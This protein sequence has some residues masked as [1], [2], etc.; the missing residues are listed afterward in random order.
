MSDFYQ[1]LRECISGYN[2][3]FAELARRTQIDRS[4]LYKIQNGQ[5]LPT[6]E[7]LLR[8]LAELK[9]SPA[10]NRRIMDQYGSLRMDAGQLALYHQLHAVLQPLLGISTFTPPR[11][12]FSVQPCGSD[13]EVLDTPAALQA[14]LAELM[15]A[16]LASETDK[17][18]MLSPYLPDSLL[19]PLACGLAADGGAAR[20]HAVWHLCCA[21][22]QGAEPQ[23][24]YL[25][26]LRTLL[27]LVFSSP[28]QYQARLCYTAA[29]A[30]GALFSAYLLFPQA[31][32]LLY[33]DNRRGLCLRGEAAESLRRQFSRQFLAAQIPHFL[34]IDAAPMADTTRGG[35]LHLQYAAPSAAQAQGTCY[36]SEDGLMLFTHTGRYLG[37]TEDSCLPPAAR[38][39]ALQQ[40]RKHCFDEQSPALLCDEQFLSLRPGVH[41]STQPDGVCLTCR[42]PQGDACRTAAL[43]EP[44]LAELF[45]GYFAYLK[46]CGMVRSAQYTAEFIDC[47]LRQLG[48]DT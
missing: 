34:Q 36:F 48:D 6:Q 18:L 47:C 24:A 14:R 17:P 44:I 26:L 19:H 46:N 11:Y 7:Q 3:S 12:E 42:L 13:I 1:L 28:V 25:D 38:R 30:A 29:P 8:L 41:L 40:L 33:A 45:N 21:P 31:A 23:Q 22:G 2:H 15:Q 37:C 16:F 4:T 5:R 27:P 43:Q 10:V 32:L 39:T 9:I 35:A 20:A